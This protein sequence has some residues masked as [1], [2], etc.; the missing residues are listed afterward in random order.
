MKR[1]VLYV[2]LGVVLIGVVAGLV[3]SRARSAAQR[4]DETRS[5]VVERGTLLVAISASGRVEPSARVSLDFEAPGRVADVRVELGDRA[6]AGDVLAELDTRQLTLQVQQAQATLQ[7]AE[8]RLAELRGGPRPAE[9]AGAEA[10]LAA[11]QA[12]VAAAAAGLDQLEAGPTDA[13]IAAARAQVAT[14]EL[15]RK[16]AQDAND[17]TRSE[18]KDEKARR[19][20]AYALYEAEKTLAAAQAQLDDLLAGGD[21]D[22]VRAGRADTQAAVARQDAAQAQ[23]DLVIAGA[24]EEEIADGEAQVAQ[25]RA[26][27]E[28][29]ELTLD[30]ATLRAPFDGIVAQIN[31][32]PGEMAPVGLPALTL[33]DASEFHLTVSVDEMDVGRLATGQPA[34]VELEALPDAVIIGTIARVAPVATFEGGVVYYAVTIDLTPR[35]APIRADMT[36]SATITVEE[37][38]DVLTIPTWV[39]RVDRTTGQTYVERRA[40]DDVERVDVELGIRY[41]GMAQILSGLSEGDEIVWISNERFGFGGEQ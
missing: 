14:A 15:Q 18:T 26:A 17:R 16:V 33:L 41:Q 27:L 30:R 1:T 39:V 6:K 13:Q 3:I 4:G 38:T 12:Q 35:D 31:V 34:R 23:L 9:V 11:A 22:A 25:A 7:S 36:A 37:L 2:V 24:T 10:N 20:A 8:A 19:Q 5:A 40:G 21:A 28:Q 29:A 32:A